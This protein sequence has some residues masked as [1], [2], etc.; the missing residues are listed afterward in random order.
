M[1]GILCIGATFT[2]DGDLLSHATT[3]QQ[4]DA[5]LLIVLTKKLRLILDYCD[6]G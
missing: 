2:A 3:L 4:L 1:L 5:Y 6:A